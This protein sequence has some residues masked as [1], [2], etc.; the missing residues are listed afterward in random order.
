MGLVG[1]LAPR[2]KG[3]LRRDPIFRE[4]ENRGS[5]EGRWEKQAEWAVHRG[6]GGPEAPQG[7]KQAAAQAGQ[8][9]GLG[10]GCGV[11]Y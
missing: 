3:E 4:R 8:A 6:L 5:G 7:R 2:G 9:A 1:E 11:E 10:T